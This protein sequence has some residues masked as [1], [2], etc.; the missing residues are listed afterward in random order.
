[1]APGVGTYGSVATRKRLL[2]GSSSY[3]RGAGELKCSGIISPPTRSTSTATTEPSPSTPRLR[4]LALLTVVVSLPRLLLLAS[5]IRAQG[6]YRWAGR[7]ELTASTTIHPSPGHCACGRKNSSAA[8]LPA[9]GNRD[10]QFLGSSM[11]ETVR[12]SYHSS[13]GS[14]KRT[15]LISTVRSHVR[16]VIVVRGNGRHQSTRRSCL[17]VEADSAGTRRAA[18]HP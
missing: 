16:F 13:A 6:I 10:Q 17:V 15:Q 7:R 11:E 18:G 2:R 14:T 8:S 1:M 9:K 3:V 12:I 5:K 4:D